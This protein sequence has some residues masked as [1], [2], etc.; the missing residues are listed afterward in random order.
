[1][2]KLLPILTTLTATALATPVNELAFNI[3]HLQ[4]PLAS[5]KG[6]QS[7]DANWGGHDAFDH[8]KEADRFKVNLLNAALKEG[9]AI[10]WNA[11]DHKPTPEEGKEYFG[12]DDDKRLE[13]V[14]EVFMLLRGSERD[15]GSPHFRN[16]KW[17]KRDVSKLCAHPDYLLIMYQ[18]SEKTGSTGEIIPCGNFFVHKYDL[19]SKLDCNAIGEAPSK[20]W[21]SATAGVL[22]EL[23]FNARI[24]D[25]HD[26][27]GPTLIRK[28]AEST[29]IMKSRP[30]AMLNA[31]NYQW[32]AME[33]FIRDKC[34]FAKVPPAE[35]ESIS[36][37]G[38]SSIGQE[39]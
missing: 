9:L 36:P 5:D 26:S 7:L 2:M 19:A 33:K 30:A 37:H 15:Y 28:L 25:I 10:A 22:H 31:D 21:I 4:S 32:F 18:H 11:G 12:T 16:F 38:D 27:Y 29:D 20:K 34:N 3:L 35:A 13:E 24:V 8:D 23:F 17:E 39:M 14:Q 1:M 6:V